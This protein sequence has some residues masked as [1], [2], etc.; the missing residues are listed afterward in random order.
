MNI[1]K[2]TIVNIAPNKIASTNGS[3]KAY[4]LTMKHNNNN[5]QQ[6][7]K[8]A[9]DITSEKM[10]WLNTKQAAAHIGVSEK[11][12]QNLNSLGRI[13]YYKMGRSNKYLQSELDRLILK[14]PKGL[15]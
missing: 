15:R 13:P 10:K 2:R 1:S 9:T 3:T 12:L 6:A 5:C 7:M 11:A 4:G 8:T 14:N